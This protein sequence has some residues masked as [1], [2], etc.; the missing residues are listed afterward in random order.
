MRQKTPLIVQ[1][2]GKPLN[3]FFQGKENINTAQK[4]KF[5]I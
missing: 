3:H 1:K 2:I 4:M 5:S